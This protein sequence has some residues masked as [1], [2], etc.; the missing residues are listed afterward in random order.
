MPMRL[1]L[2]V[3]LAALLSAACK[4]DDLNSLSGGKPVNDT[5]PRSGKPVAAD[6]LTEYRGHVVGF[7]NTHCRDDFVAN[8][9]ERP[10]DRAFFDARIDGTR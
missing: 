5:C 8:T 6:S 3:L 7:C 10:A 1:I 9:A 2:T 4:S